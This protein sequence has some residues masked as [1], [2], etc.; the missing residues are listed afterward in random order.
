MQSS[1]LRGMEK[2]TFNA[3]VNG[4]L[5]VEYPPFNECVTS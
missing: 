5:S 3:L 1:S 4:R 2:E